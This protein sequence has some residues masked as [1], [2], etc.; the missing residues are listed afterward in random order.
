M[1]GE[2]FYPSAH[3]LL[4][5]LLLSEVLK[6]IHF[7]LNFHLIFDSKDY[8]GRQLKGFCRTRMNSNNQFR[9]LIESR[10]Y[11]GLRGKGMSKVKL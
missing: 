11:E 2:H 3:H 5:G 9:V 10:N 1:A 4:E 8:F 6:R 7:Y